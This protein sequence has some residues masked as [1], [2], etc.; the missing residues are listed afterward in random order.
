[1]QLTATDHRDRIDAAQLGRPQHFVALE[2]ANATR[3]ARAA[4]KRRLATAV[5]ADS[6]RALAADLVVD[7]PEELV[8]IAVHELLL[9]CR[10]VGE[11]VVAELLALAGLRGHEKVGD[12]TAKYGHLTPRQRAVLADVLRAVDAAV[13]E[14][15]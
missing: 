1:V 12:G 15:A 3:L 7:T 2:G 14:A 4:Q 5:D 10:Q 6:A 13:S 11:R 8:T 9:S